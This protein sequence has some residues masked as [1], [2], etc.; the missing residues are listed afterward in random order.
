M[1]SYGEREMTEDITKICIK[2]SKE[3]ELDMFPEIKSVEIVFNGDLIS[4]FENFLVNYIEYVQDWLKKGIRPRKEY[5]HIVDLLSRLLE[6]IRERPQKDY[7]R[8]LLAFDRRQIRRLYLAIS[9]YRDNIPTTSSS[10]RELTIIDS[11][12]DII[13][14]QAQDSTGNECRLCS[15]DISEDMLMRDLGKRCIACVC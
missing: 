3:R 14:K 11:V 5:E 15:L 12:M 10:D 2:C 7:D 8:L 4:W 13:K 1:T 9:D 6:R